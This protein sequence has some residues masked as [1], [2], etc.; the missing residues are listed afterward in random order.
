MRN[1]RHWKCHWCSEI[2]HAD[3]NKQNK[4]AHLAK[5]HGITKTGRKTPNTA[6]MTY[7]PQAGEKIRG[8][9]AYTSLSWHV[10]RPHFI[11]T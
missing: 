11:D 2:Q 7:K 8:S 4:E 6:G 5:H 9:E 3:A 1:R 10:L